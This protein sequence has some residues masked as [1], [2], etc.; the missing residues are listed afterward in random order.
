MVGEAV[1]LVAPAARSRPAVFLS[2]LRLHQFMVDARIGVL[3]QRIVARECLVCLPQCAVVWARVSL[4]EEITMW[5]FVLGAF[6][7]MCAGVTM[8]A[9]LRM[10][11]GYDPSG[12]CHGCPLLRCLDDEEG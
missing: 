11:E 4:G 6:L 2:A 7:G 12:T 9:M 8:V 1:G 10:S 5:W 3:S